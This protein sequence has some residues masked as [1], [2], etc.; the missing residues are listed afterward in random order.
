M[1]NEEQHPYRCPS[2]LK[3]LKCLATAL[4]LS[5]TLSPA[6]PAHAVVPVPVGNLPNGP[7]YAVAG[8][9]ADQ[10]LRLTLT[11]VARSPAASCLADVTFVDE[12]GMVRSH[13]S[14]TIAAGHSQILDEPFSTTTTTSARSAPTPNRADLPTRVLLSPYH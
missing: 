11:N 5:L 10:I 4:V 3:S 12:T 9:T 13:S 6:L 7:L 8:I 1:K 14:Q 2:A